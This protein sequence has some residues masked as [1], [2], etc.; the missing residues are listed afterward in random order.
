MTRLE[1][2]VRTLRRRL[3]RDAESAWARRFEPTYAWLLD[4][5]Y[6]RRGLPRR[7]CGE[8]V[9]RIRPAFRALQDDREPTVFAALRRLVR[10]GM[11]VF[12]VGASFGEYAVVLARWCGPE[13]R[14]VAFEPTPISRAAL[15]DHLELNG[16]VDRVEIVD[17]AIADYVGTGTLHAAGRSGEN[18]LHPSYFGPGEAEDVSVPVT[19]IDAHCQVSG[20]TPDVIKLDVEGLEFHA[21][22]GARATL[23]RRRPPVVV[24]LHAASWAGVGESAER[25]EA[26]VRELGYRAIALDGQRTALRQS[27]HVLLEPDA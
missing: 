13:G 6:G 14:V 20:R 15:R 17:A 7:L 27:G 5:V 25:A 4:S 24:E 3:P 1:R 19:T 12:D 10:P 22:R 9:V 21:L 2:A 18:T 11:I 26:L 8:E 16:L 23:L